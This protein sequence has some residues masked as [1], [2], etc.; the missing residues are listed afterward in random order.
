RTPDTA[1]WP[2]P[3]WTA[4]AAETPGRRPA[5]SGESTG[6]RGTETGHSPAA[7]QSAARPEASRRTAKPAADR[8]KC[9][10]G[11]WPIASRDTWR[12][13]QNWKYRKGEKELA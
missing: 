5:R 8:T 3:R 11:D 7:A 10:S 2:R 4:G 12:C 13:P 9:R 6:R 1:G